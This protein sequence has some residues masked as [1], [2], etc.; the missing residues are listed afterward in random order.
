MGSPVGRKALLR[1]IARGLQIL[2]RRYGTRRRRTENIHADR[3]GAHPAQLEPVLIEAVETRR[4]LLPLDGELRALA[5]RIQSMGGMVVAYE[6]TAR[7]RF[8]R[9]RLAE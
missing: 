4:K 7:L 8:D 1:G 9:D 6:Q 5:A 2:A 3:S